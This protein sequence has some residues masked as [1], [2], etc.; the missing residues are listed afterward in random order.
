M[1]LIRVSQKKIAAN[2]AN[3]RKSHGPSTPAGKARSSRNACSHHL[4]ARKFTIHPVWQQRIAAV[5]GPAIESVE[6]PAERE[7]LTRYLFLMQ[8]I[9]ELAS[10]QTRLLNDSIAR[11]HGDFARGVHHFATTN[12]LFLAI[13]ARMHALHRDANRAR[14]EWKRAQRQTT[15]N[16]V[17][18]KPLTMAAAAGAPARRHALP[19]AP[20]PKCRSTSRT[21][22]D[23]AAN[24][25]HPP[26]SF[27]Y[28]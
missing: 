28:S 20:A 5:V 26:R 9:E 21:H 24:A 4:Y 12:P 27:A 6:N 7:P 18:K 19:P 3:G 10:F 23:A 17:E 2:R 25:R 14:L 1:S 15:P 8:W 16:V 13:G 22:T 11:H